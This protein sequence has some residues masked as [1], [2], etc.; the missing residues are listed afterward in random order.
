MKRKVLTRRDFLRAAAVTPLAGALASAVKLPAPSESETRSRVVLVRDAK[1]LVSFKRPDADIIQAML[2][3]AVTKLFDV[4]DPVEAWKKIIKPSD[5][6]GIKSNVYGYLPTTREV[7]QAIKR[8]VMDAGVEEDHIGIDDRNVRRHPVFKRATAFINARPARTHH[9]SG[10]G[11]CIKNYIM[12]V[13]RP[14]AYHADSCADLGSIWNDYKLKEKTRLNILVMLNPQF[15]TVGPHSYSDKYVWEYKGL[16]VSQDPVAVDVTGLKIIQ[17]K[18]LEYFGEQRP[19]GT[20]AKHI[21]MADE[22]H[23]LG[24]SDPAKIELIKFGWK[25]GILI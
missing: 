20:P 9:W 25:D 6:V 4:R 23:N 11:T 18:R 15:H 5:V 3:S 17:A 12:F 14:S 19:M 7:E 16:L 13:P 21:R 22:R 8:R 1:A 24:H 2:D 10:L